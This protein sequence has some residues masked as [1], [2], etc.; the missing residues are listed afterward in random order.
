MKGNARILARATYHGLSS[1]VPQKNIEKMRKRE[2]ERRR[3][4]IFELTF[5]LLSTEVVL[6]SINICKLVSCKYYS[7]DF[8]RFGNCLADSNSNF[9]VET[10]F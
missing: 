10:I 2:R 3:E 6:E 4:M 1:A 5:P 8:G 9:V 7:N